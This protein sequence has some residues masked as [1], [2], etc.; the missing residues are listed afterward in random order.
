MKKT[1]LLEIKKPCS[2]NLDRMNKTKNGFFCDLCSNEVI[3]FSNKNDVEL[4]KLFSSQSEINICGKFKNRQINPQNSTKHKFS[5]PLKYVFLVSL[6]YGKNV[7]SQTKL[8]NNEKDPITNQNQKIPSRSII[9][10]MPSRIK[11]K[12]NL[13]IFSIISNLL[14]PDET[15]RKYSKDITVYFL[16]STTDAKFDESSNTY[17]SE[18]ELEKDFSN[19]YAVITY[20]NKTITKFYP[21][22]SN[23]INNKIY[24]QNIN[25]TLEDFKNLGIK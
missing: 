3:D 4:R 25:L 8:G 18:V 16:G 7:F 2:A 23:K 12:T 22:D 14:L 24:Y 19:F 1:F 5:I 20:K 11:D 9:L 13:H 10:G 17:I 21:F 6:L 15:K